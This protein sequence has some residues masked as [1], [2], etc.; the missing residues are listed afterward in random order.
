MQTTASFDLGHKK[1]SISWIL[2]LEAVVSCHLG[3]MF[4]ALGALCV[5]Y[6]RPVWR[7]KGAEGERGE[8][9]CL[10]GWGKGHTWE[11]V[12][13]FLCCPH[14]QSLCPP[15]G[16]CKSFWGCLSDATLVPVPLCSLDGAAQ[17]RSAATASGCLA[18]LL[19][20]GWRAAQGW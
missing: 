8:G 12:W 4:A 18:L 17:R 10:V 20:H 6:W 5:G 19:R 15:Y 13:P 9:S 2:Y 3:L 14:R 16:G 1:T 7:E 11:V